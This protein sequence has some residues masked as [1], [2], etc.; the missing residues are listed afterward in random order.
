MRKLYT[1]DLCILD[2]RNLKIEEVT[3]LMI[4]HD[5]TI[6]YEITSKVK[7]SLQ[8]KNYI[9]LISENDKETIIIREKGKLLIEEMLTAR[10]QPSIPK[11]TV[12]RSTRSITNDLN[13]FILDFR[14]L[15][16]GL[17]P[18]SMGS[19][20]A[21]SEKMRRWMSENPSY[22]K[23]DVMKA[24]KAYIKSQNNYQYLQQADYFIYKKD[25]RGESSRLSAFI[26][27]ADTPDDDWTIKL[28]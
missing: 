20:S 23:E 14:N 4:L 7:E 12:R 16:K 15:W 27:E 13:D 3:S 19:P 24:A 5:G 28:S 11:R 1:I 6:E 2:E 25:A 8:D 21:C 18:G 26:D 22:T 10:Y 9:K 17:K